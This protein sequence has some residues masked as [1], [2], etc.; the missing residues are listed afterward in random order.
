M[1]RVWKSPRNLKRNPGYRENL[2]PPRVKSAIWE[3]ITGDEER[4]ETQRVE[5]PQSDLQR[6]RASPQN[7]QTFVSNYPHPKQEQ[8]KCGENGEPVLGASPH[9]ERADHEENRGDQYLRS[10]TVRGIG[11]SRQS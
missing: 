6:R 7:V 5:Q 10:Y 8:H 1:D 11:C 2:R 4:N 9:D 3:E